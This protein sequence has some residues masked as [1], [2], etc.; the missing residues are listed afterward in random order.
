[1]SMQ[2]QLDLFGSSA[3]TPQAAPGS[4]AGTP[5]PAPRKDWSG[6][7]KTAFSTLG[8]SNHSKEQRVQR[9]FYATPPKAVE[10]LLDMEKFSHS[11]LEPCCGLGHISR[12]LVAHGHE[13]DNR[14][15]EDRGFG[16]G[17]MDFLAT[18]ERDL[19]ADIIT[20][21]PYS[22][23]QEF[24][25]KALDVV[26][27]GH[28]VAMFLKLTF[29]EGKSRKRM[30]ERYPPKVVYVSSSRLSCGRNG[31]EWNPSAVAYAWYIWEKG[32]KGDTVVK[33]FN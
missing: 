29:L 1:M 11:I 26:G 20:N 18:D 14:D 17:G 21:P 32:Y 8:A 16:R 24:V 15:I 7:S 12:V 9:D 25:E 13:V 30:F 10:M 31:T 5:S 4:A 19:D 27:A 28:K 6:N 33:W 22:L 23:A 2:E 3:P